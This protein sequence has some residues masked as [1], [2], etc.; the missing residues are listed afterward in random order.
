M[1]GVLRA[2]GGGSGRRTVAK[3]R[4]TRRQ[5]YTDSMAEAVAGIGML[6]VGVSGLLSSRLTYWFLDR[7]VHMDR[8]QY[9]KGWR[10]RY[11]WLM[12]GF[13]TVLGLILLVQGV[14]AW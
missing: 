10:A 6:L 14:A 7:S 2:G 3:T 8:E 11:R 13:A 12:P 1:A 5:T 9:K 4:R